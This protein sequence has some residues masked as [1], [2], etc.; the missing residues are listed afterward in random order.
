MSYSGEHYIKVLNDEEDERQ[1]FKREEQLA[2]E[3]FMD[4]RVVKPD[5]GR[6]THV[7]NG[8]VRCVQCGEVVSS[9]VFCSDECKA[10]YHKEVSEWL[11]GIE[12]LLPSNREKK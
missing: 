4:L 7:V 10:R 12:D 11:D 5:G 2:G 1:R 8:E 9:L 3:H 6:I